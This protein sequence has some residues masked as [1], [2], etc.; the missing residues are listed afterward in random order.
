[1]RLTTDGVGSKRQKNLDL[2]DQIIGVIRAERVT[3]VSMNKT[4]EAA[5]YWYINRLGSHE[6]ELARME[7]QAW[8]ESG[9]LPDPVVANELDR[10]LRV[11]KLRYARQLAE[12][13]KGPG[14]RKRG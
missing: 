4:T 1:M 13:A 8:L 10:L 11:E 6:R 2:D 12:K 9:V 5:V 3:G 7:C 14:K